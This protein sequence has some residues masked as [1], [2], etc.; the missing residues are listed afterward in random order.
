MALVRV[1]SFSALP[2]G[3]VMQVTVGEESY[4]VCNVGGELHALSGDC[5]H[6]GGPLGHGALHGSTLVCP[7]HAWEF[8]CRTGAD[9]LDP[10]LR[11]SKF[12]VE[13]RGDDI[14]IDVP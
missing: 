11:V 1:G 14:L 7:W 10:D 9:T 3:E 8:D 12:S 5:P 2:P 13:V 4:A 6:R